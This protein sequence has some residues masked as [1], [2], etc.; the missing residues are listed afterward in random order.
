MNKRGDEGTPNI[1]YVGIAIAVLAVVGFG[2]FKILGGE[3]NIIDNLIPNFL[4]GGD[5]T[6][7]AVKYVRFNMADYNLEYYDEAKWVQI[8]DKISLNGEEYNLDDFDG[9]YDVNNRLKEKEDDLF[10]SKI[11]FNPKTNSWN[12]LKEKIDEQYDTE[13]QGLY[14]SIY[15]HLFNVELNRNFHTFT[16]SSDGDYLFY[17]IDARAGVPKDV[18][19]TYIYGYLRYSPSGNKLEYKGY[20]EPKLVY[21]LI[22]GLTL[23]TW[24]DVESVE[25]KELIISYIDNTVSKALSPVEIKGKNY[26]VDI[27]NERNLVIDLTRAGEECK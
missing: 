17:V 4:K 18:D 15:L 21:G 19:S 6:N 16:S 13:E 14:T 26:C 2:A 7:N 3:S 27:Q 24:E 10:S 5:A 25:L 20:S 11:R 1:I 12:E 22:E 8:K 9:L 23:P